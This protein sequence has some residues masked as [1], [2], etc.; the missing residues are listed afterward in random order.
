MIKTGPFL[1]AALGAAGIAVAQM[2]PAPHEATRAPRIDVVNL[3][4]L[5]AARA[6]KVDAILQ[7]AAAKMRV[8]H[9]ELGG[10]GDETSRATFHAAIEAIRVDTD[11]QLASVLSPEEIATLRSAMPAAPRLEAMRFKRG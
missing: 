8:V 5:D 1:L 11:Q 4:N 6:G 3:L 2:A 10:R 9:D 7:G